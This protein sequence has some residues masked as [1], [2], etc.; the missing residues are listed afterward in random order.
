NASRVSGVNFQLA[1]SYYSIQDVSGQDRKA[2]RTAIGAY[3]RNA[4][5]KER[6]KP[7]LKRLAGSRL[8]YLQYSA[9][10]DL[11]MEDLIQDSDVG[12]LAGLVANRQLTDPR[13][14]GI[15]VQQIGRFRA[16]RFS[17]VLEGVVRDPKESVSVRAEALRTLEEFGAQE[18]LKALAPVVA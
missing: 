12:W 10:V 16:R 14:R 5:D 3:L 9:V 7:E 4:G 1:M 18:S 13:A 15:V 17:D 6:L 2:Y 8:P 11:K